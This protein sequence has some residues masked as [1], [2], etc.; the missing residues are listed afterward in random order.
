MQA[1]TD[2]IDGS[3]IEERQSCI[4]WNYKNAEQEHGNMFIHDLY[5]QIEKIIKPT[6]TEVIYGNGY[7]EVKPLGIKKQRLVDLLMEKISANSLIDFLFYLGID[8][9]DEPVYELLKSD[10]VNK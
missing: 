6:N 9:S 3:F 2:N 5:N 10:K 1:Y 8:S 7:L 4:L